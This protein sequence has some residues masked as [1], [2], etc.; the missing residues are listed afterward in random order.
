MGEFAT[1]SFATLMNKY[2]DLQNNVLQSVRRLAQDSKSAAP[3][4]FLLV[5]FQ[6]QQVTQIGESI[7]N[8][9]SQ[10]NQVIK[11]AVSNQMR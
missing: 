2:S 7:S 8:M 5:Q 6:M 9:I 1:L 10:V 3:G 11:N 4:K